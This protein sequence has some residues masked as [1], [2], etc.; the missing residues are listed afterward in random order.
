[1]N[2]NT[3][4]FIFML[5]HKGFEITPNDTYL[6][7]IMYGRIATLKNVNIVKVNEQV[8]NY[9]LKKTKTPKAIHILTVFERQKQ[10]K[11][12][13]KGIREEANAKN[14][15]YEKVVEVIENG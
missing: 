15:D 3:V 8:V 12:L 14:Q 4:D 5:R 13:L 2:V 9:I 7:D 11:E 10:F 1:M 6:L